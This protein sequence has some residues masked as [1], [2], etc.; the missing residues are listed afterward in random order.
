L[1]GKSQSQKGVWALKF[2]A[3]KRTVE[4]CGGC[5]MAFVS[6]LVLMSW[7]LGCLWRLSCY[8]TY[9]NTNFF[10]KASWNCPLEFNHLVDLMVVFLIVHA[11]VCSTVPSATIA[12]EHL[13]LQRSLRSTSVAD[14]LSSSGERQGVLSA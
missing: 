6:R 9:W 4:L 1:G 11:P 2:Q 13:F 14:C 7:T 8:T 3:T 5:A 10:L 12:C